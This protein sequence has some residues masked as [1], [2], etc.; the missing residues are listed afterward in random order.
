MNRLRIAVLPGD[1]IGR[2]VIPEAVKVLSRVADCTHL[3]ME[4][5][6]AL[7]GGAALTANEEPLPRQTLRLCQESDAVLLGAIGDLVAGRHQRRLHGVGL[8]LVQS[9]AVRCQSHAHRL[10]VAQA[11]ARSPPAS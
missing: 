5:K 7:I 6:E 1:G 8:R 10:R 9:A 11:S 3:A 2:E 4:F